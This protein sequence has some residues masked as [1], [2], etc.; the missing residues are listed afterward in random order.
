MAAT[1]NESGKKYA[2][3][4]LAHYIN[5]SASGEAA[6]YERIGKDLDEFNKDMNYDT[7]DTENIWG[8]VEVDISAAKPTAEVKTYYAR[9]GSR[10]AERLQDIVDSRLEGDDLKTDVVEVHL[11]KTSS[12][13]EGSTSYEA[14]KESAWIEVTSNGGDTK[15]VQTPYTIHYAGDPVKGTFDIS[16]RTFTAAS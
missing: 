11:W 15:G 16:T 10:L 1:T 2:R 7:D 9:E 8:E 6:V 4:L 14:V 3:R 5:A 13:A 12:S